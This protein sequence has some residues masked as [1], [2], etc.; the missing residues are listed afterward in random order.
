MEF[1]FEGEGASAALCFGQGIYH[2]VVWKVFPFP[3]EPWFLKRSGGL[4]LKVL[5]DC[6]IFNK[7]IYFR[8]AIYM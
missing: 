4:W 1:Y 2:E 6:G 5:Y 3:T 7:F 8:Y